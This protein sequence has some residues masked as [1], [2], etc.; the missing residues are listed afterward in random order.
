VKAGVD[1]R[2]KIMSEREMQVD[3]KENHELPLLE[4]AKSF[5]IEICYG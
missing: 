2:K 1:Y 4:N 3:F 5:L